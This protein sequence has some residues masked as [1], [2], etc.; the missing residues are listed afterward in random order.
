[1][2]MSEKPTFRVSKIT[3]TCKQIASVT[4]KK[5]DIADKKMVRHLTNRLVQYGLE[6]IEVYHV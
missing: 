4:C 5:V 2:A 6:N 3:N 1:M